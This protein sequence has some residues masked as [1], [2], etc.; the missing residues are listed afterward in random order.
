MKR[1]FALLYG[2]ACYGI[3]FITFLYLIGFMGNLLVPRSI[4][5][6]PAAATSTALII[7]VCLIALFGVQHSVMARP[8]F[9]EIWTRI[10]P[11]SIERSTYVLLTSVVL[12][13]L[14]WQWRPLTGIVW[15]ADS[16]LVQ[17]MHWMIFF[18]GIS[19]VLLSTFVI[20]HFDLFGL[21]QVWLN[22]R[23]KSYSHP[24]FRVTFFY[25]FVRH[26]LYVGWILFFW[27]APTMTVGHLLMAVGM[28]GYMLIAIRYEE[29]DL[30][31]FLGDDYANY[32]D[33][34]PML[35][36]KFGKSHETVKVAG[37]Q[38]LPH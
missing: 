1:V 20:D 11:K 21:R 29:R 17:G 16:A 14:Y 23:Q 7:N 32:R 5:V 38:P 26:P 15:Q 22:F 3:F 36:P 18:G 13:L 6:G 27:G 33:K 30:V 31:R 37:N 9:K 12:I 25:K 35:I 4:D 2:V 8:G 34:V 10:V 24:G 19:L 28:T